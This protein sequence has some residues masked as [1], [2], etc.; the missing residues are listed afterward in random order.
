MGM[1]YRVTFL[2][3]ADG[4]PEFHRDYLSLEAARMEGRA[5]AGEYLP[6]AHSLHIYDGQG[7][8]VERWIHVEDI[9]KRA[10]KARR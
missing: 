4:V 5:W 2:A 7:L 1:R 10:G 9:W 6:G 8:L 3:P